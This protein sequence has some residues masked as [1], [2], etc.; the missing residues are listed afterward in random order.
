MIDPHADPRLVL[1]QIVD[2]IRTH[3]AEFRDKEVVHQNLLR[4]ACGTQLAAS[5]LERTDQLLLLR[6]DGNARL[7]RP[8]LLLD[9][10]IQVFKL[11][12]TVRMVGALQRLL[13]RLQAVAHHV[14]Q[15]SHHAMAGLVA[16]RLE[17]RGQFAHFLSVHRSG[18]SGSPRLVGSTS[19][20]RSSRNMGS[21]TTADLR[22]PPGRRTRPFTARSSGR[23]SSRI[24]C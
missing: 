6:V 24:P 14:E 23:W 13:I 2:P 9:R 17:L 7:S 1:G 12:V 3:A 18:D 4:L 8:Q 22:P 15:L 16:L 5:V 11:C 20:S 10:R 21:S 19:L